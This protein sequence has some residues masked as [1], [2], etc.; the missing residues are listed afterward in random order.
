VADYA[1]SVVRWVRLGEGGGGSASHRNPNDSIG[2]TVATL[3]SPADGGWQPY[4]VG[5]RGS[6]GGGGSHATGATAVDD[7]HTD[8]HTVTASS[9]EGNAAELAHRP[10]GV[11]VT[12]DGRALLTADAGNTEVQIFW[13]QD[14]GLLP[15]ERG[16]GGGEQAEEEETSSWDA[17]AADVHAATQVRW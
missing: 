7:K 8:R 4:A 12:P 5:R 11:A 15:V 1:N 13:L 10:A 14:V 9:A 6:I 16:W 17:A 3:P 2:R